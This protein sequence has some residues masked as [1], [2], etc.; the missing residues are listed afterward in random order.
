MKILFVGVFTPQSSNFGQALA[1]EELGHEVVRYSFRDVAAE[2]CGT[3]ERDFHLVLLCK[4]EV[5]DLMI[6]SK[7]NTISPYVVHACKQFTKVVMWYMDPL[8]GNYTKELV[9]KMEEADHVFC[10]HQR[11]VDVVKTFRPDA[12]RIIDGVYGTPS[13]F[14]MN[15][16]I[17]IYDAM[18]FGSLKEDRAYYKKLFGFTHIEG[19]YNA[20]LV[21]AIAN[22]KINL[23]F[24]SD[25]CGSDRVYTIMTV[26]GFVM[27]D[28]WQGLEDEFIDG[29]EIIV[30]NGF[31]DFADKL[32]YYLKY[33]NERKEIAL[34]GH[35]RNKQYSKLNWAKTLLEK[36]NG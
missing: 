4:R 26:G 35:E 19:I 20:E 28:Y 27:T 33:E 18:F 15:S 29:K 22:T 31:D 8:D 34:A 9:G 7:G 10:A 5:P 23:N 1:L 21:H 13:V 16:D 36:I 14:P 3:L 24:C 17:Q 6:I 2:L 11:V 32:R 25:M 30:F 12:S